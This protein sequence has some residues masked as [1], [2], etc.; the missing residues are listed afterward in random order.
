MAEMKRFAQSQPTA[1]CS[2]FT[3]APIHPTN[4]WQHIDWYKVTRQVR[5]LQARNRSPMAAIG[6]DKSGQVAYGKSLTTLAHS[7]VQRQSD[8]RKTSDGKQR[9]EH[10]GS[11]QR[12]LEHSQEA[13]GRRTHAQAKRLQS[14]T[15]ETGVHRIDSKIILL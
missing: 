8:G 14:A 13:N 11:G 6:G 4:G 2:S 7:L 15:P 10:S 12:N 3:D 5:W 1:T 9:Q